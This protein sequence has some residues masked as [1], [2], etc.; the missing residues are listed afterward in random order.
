MQS[1]YAKLEFDHARSL[2]MSL[3]PGADSEMD[4][5]TTFTSFVEQVAL[6]I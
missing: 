6:K 1:R 5:E 2:W 4:Y 3:R